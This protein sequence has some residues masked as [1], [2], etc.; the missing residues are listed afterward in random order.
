MVPSSESTK[1]AI[2]NLLRG[3]SNEKNSLSCS[4]APVR[5]NKVSIIIR[6]QSHNP[7]TIR[8]C[9][10]SIDKYVKNVQYFSENL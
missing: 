1:N 10:I 5:E 7:L 3:N 2:G 8:P 6:I 4:M 9:S